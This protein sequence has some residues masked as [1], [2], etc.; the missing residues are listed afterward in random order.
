MIKPFFIFY[1][2][3]FCFLNLKAQLSNINN[4][5]S[6]LNEQK[7]IKTTSKLI[8]VW[9]SFDTWGKYDRDYKYYCQGKLNINEYKKIH[10]FIGVNLFSDS[11]KIFAPI[12]YQVKVPCDYKK[13]DIVKLKIRIYKYCSIVEGKPFFLVE[14][15][16]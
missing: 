16:L 14:E 6:F 10:S 7:N 13:G 12:N 2:S 15:I 8:V 9:A 1:L 3:V 4:L 5:E 11:I